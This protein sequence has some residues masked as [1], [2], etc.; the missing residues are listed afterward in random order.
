MIAAA[1]RQAK[2]LNEEF[3]DGQPVQWRELANIPMPVGVQ[4]TMQDPKALTLQEQ[5]A[6]EEVIGDE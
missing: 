4:M 2:L 3:D 6:T 1:K 5:D